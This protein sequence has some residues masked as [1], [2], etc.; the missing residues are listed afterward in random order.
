[1][2]L[3]EQEDLAIIGGAVN[4][5]KQA[6]IVA[7]WKMVTL[8]NCLL[9]KHGSISQFNYLFRFLGYQHAYH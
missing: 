4:M 6:F 3:W 9:P 5:G 2:S 7:A 1:M 8:Q